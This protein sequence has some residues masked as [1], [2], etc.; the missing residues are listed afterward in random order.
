M[1]P[2]ASVRERQFKKR[3]KNSN[4]LY[5]LSYFKD[6]CGYILFFP[7]EEERNEKIAMIGKTELLIKD[8]IIKNK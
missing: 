6:K 4:I 8:E 1:K 3:L 7:T 5:R 2:F